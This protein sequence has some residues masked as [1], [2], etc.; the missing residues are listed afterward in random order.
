MI[1]LSPEDLQIIRDLLSAH[2]PSGYEVRV[3]GS[4]C[5]GQARE[6]SDL[7]LMIYGSD[8]LPEETLEDLKDA[9][10][11]SDLPIMVD[12]LDW[13]QISEEFRYTIGNHYEILEW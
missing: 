3:F 12:V 9:F 10:A 2:L 13:H 5:N 4:R 1:K 7:D 11:E 8:P 6:F